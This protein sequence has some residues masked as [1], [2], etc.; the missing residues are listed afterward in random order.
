MKMNITNM[1][2]QQR[3]IDKREA[4]QWKQSKV[5]REKRHDAYVLALTIH[6]SQQL[7]END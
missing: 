7:K 2:Q 1:E 6:T 5:T 4:K 3:R